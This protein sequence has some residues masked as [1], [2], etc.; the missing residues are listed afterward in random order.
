M[1]TTWCTGLACVV[2]GGCAWNA[3]TN[4]ALES[5][6]EPPP[7][8]LAS[9]DVQP[10]GNEKVMV[11]LALSGGGSRAALFSSHVMLE[12]GR[13]GL[14]DE[15]DAI[16]SVSGGS[17]AAAYY[18]ISR[19]PGDPAD[20]APRVWSEDEVDELMRR[21]YIRRWFG[22]QF[23]PWN[24]ARYWTTAFDRSDIMAQ[25][26]A[27]NLFDRPLSG[28]DL[29]LGD[30]NPERPHLI[31]N[32]TN[33]TRN[34]FSEGKQYGSVFTFTREDFTELLGSDVDEYSLAR[35]VM[36]SATFPAVFQDMTLRDWR[37]GKPRYMHV[38][39]GGN[40]DNLG[41]VS[42]KR[43]LRAAEGWPADRRP[44]RYV[45]ISVDAYTEPRGVDR[46]DA[47][48]RSYMDRF[49]DSNFMDSID[50]LLTGS[51]WGLLAQ[52][53]SD[54]AEL[55]RLRSQQLDAAPGVDVAQAELATKADMES[56]DAAQQAAV[57]SPSSE[58]S[59]VSP[60]VPPDTGASSAHESAGLPQSWQPR[61]L[62]QRL[63]FW[64]IEF[65][66]LDGPRRREL[67]KIATDFKISDEGARNVE[68]AAE[69]LVE[70]KAGRLAAVREAL[71]LPPGP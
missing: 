36:A 55:E 45:V 69:L 8:S 71:G 17:L 42:V 51:R 57:P 13:H 27:D 32:A 33:A 40:A 10:R 63:L 23:W 61:D 67:N 37:S 21:N 11:V 34:P 31:L 38:F 29:E 6:A 18:C 46:D 1:R 41:L 19:D 16:S 39:D 65:A 12:L 64:H 50:A 70:S 7:R 9:F 26:F 22:N 54:P 15:V 44:D 56:W 35:A 43:L 66:G 62:G 68:E 58:A 14:L 3:H 52:F 53:I 30:L 49:V 4:E 2:L 24:I 20:I 60:D 25:T 48:P 47:D 28:R 59:R 5:G